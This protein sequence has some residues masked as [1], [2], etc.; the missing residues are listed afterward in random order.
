MII[1]CVLCELCGEHFL[2]R[3]LL[4][5]RN[6]PTLGVDPF[7]SFDANA[8]NEGA[9]SNLRVSLELAEESDRIVVRGIRAED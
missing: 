2:S 9:S 6:V 1:L 4:P 3:I 5:S 8:R 7:V